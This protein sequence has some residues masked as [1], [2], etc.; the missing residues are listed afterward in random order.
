MTDRIG[1]TP[2]MDPEGLRCFQETL[3]ASKCYLEYG[4]GGSTVYACD[5][6]KV[7]LV[8]SIESDK[9]WSDKVCASIQNADAK[10][11][12][13][14]CD[15]GEVGDWS[16]PKTKDR[17]GDFWTYSVNPWQTARAGNHVPDTI[18]IDGRFRVAT[19]LY[20]LLCAR[21]GTTIL[22]D[23]Y[24]DRPYYFVVENFCRLRESRG[25][26]GVFTVAQNFSMP[27]IAAA[28]AKYSIVWD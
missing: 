2:H 12:M 15:L 17:I 10:L 27:D 6:A 18:L 16:F 28:I 22:F 21:V 25:R 9:A 19:F 7:P 23:D 11:L 14:H 5:V 20:S 3:A 26:M 1:P 4:S 8:I 13:H 24:L